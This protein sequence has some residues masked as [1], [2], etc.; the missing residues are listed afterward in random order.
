[1]LE[2]IMIAVVMAIALLLAA[3]TA[4]V[5]AI[6]TAAAFMEAAKGEKPYESNT[7]RLREKNAG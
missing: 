3:L 1:M 7:D 4:A 5:L 2:Y 6:Y